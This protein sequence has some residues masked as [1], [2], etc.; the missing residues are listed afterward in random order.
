MHNTR[1]RKQRELQHP[2]ESRTK[3]TRATICLDQP[4]N[5]PYTIHPQ[6][7]PEECRAVRDDLTALHGF[8]QEFAKYRSKRANFPGDED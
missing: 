5:D 7:T 3:P 6:P 4:T 2:Q 8:P 1:K